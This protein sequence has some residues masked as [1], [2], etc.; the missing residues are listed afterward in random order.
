MP[1]LR[2]GI[3]GGILLLR[4]SLPYCAFVESLNRRLGGSQP[5]GPTLRLGATPRV[6]VPPL[7]PPPAATETPDCVRESVHT[8]S[9]IRKELGKAN[10]RPAARRRVLHSPVSSK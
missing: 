4:S 1:M 3:S 5:L 8:A 2:F 9:Q 10:G 6:P 7:S